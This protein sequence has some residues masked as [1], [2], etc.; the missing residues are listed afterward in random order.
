MLGCFSSAI[1]NHVNKVMGRSGVH[2]AVLNMASR[3]ELFSVAVKWISTGERKSLGRVAE[4]N[5]KRGFGT[6][7]RHDTKEMD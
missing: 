3:L 2:S 5:G 6:Q 7:R 4:Q 1:G